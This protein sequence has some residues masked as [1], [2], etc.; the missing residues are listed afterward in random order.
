MKILFSILFSLFSASILAQ[1]T[2]SANFYY[3]KGMD[4]KQARRWLVASAQ[5][6]KAIHLNPAYTAAY[7]ENANVCLEMRKTDDALHNF[8]KAYE[9]D[10]ANPI[11]GPALMD[12]YFS[13]HQ[14]QQAIDFAL[15][16]KTCPNASRIEALS[17]FKMQDYG[18]AEKLLL[19]LVRLYP[20]DAELIY[21][22]G[23]TYVEMELE[24]K[25][26]PYYQKAV[27]LDNSKSDWLF[28]LG[29]LA[30]N[31]EDYKNAVT[32]FNQAADKG[33]KQS[34]EFTE[35]L[36]YAYIFSGDFEKGE[37][38]LLDVMEKK[39]GS[40]DIMRDLAQVYYDRKMYDKSLEFCQKLMELDMKD[41]KA[42][43]QAGLCFQK[44][45]Q[46]ERGQQMCDRAIELDPSLA[47]L[48]QKKMSAGL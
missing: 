14:Y 38:L 18:N 48:R 26:I 37:K 21:T 35:N 32:Y 30:Y 39:R 6:E 23:R 2:D 17:Y 41:G 4:E 31:T 33:F 9:L 25:A 15:K 42:L 3:L 7:L 34:L 1:T 47:P 12:L 20:A 43:Y 5:F 16:C 24:K 45:G 19:K 13:Y 28:E 46:V 10:P 36:G 22:L 40:K 11:A 44:K 29:M 27:Q 8:E